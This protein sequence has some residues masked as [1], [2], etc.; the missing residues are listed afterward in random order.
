M[1]IKQK[2]LLHAL[3][4]LTKELNYPTLKISDKGITNIEI[5]IIKFAT[6]RIR[7][8]KNDLI[9]SKVS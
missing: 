2:K 5:E 9:N 7:E 4:E 6:Q 3:T 8:L 1:D